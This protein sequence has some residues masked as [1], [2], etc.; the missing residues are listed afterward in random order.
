MTVKRRVGPSQGQME[1]VCGWQDRLGGQ[2]ETQITARRDVTKRGVNKAYC[3]NGRF[4]LICT[5]TEAP[6]A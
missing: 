4:R 6:A 3:G 2:D 1:S 5:K